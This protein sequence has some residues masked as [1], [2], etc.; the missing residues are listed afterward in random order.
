[1]LQPVRLLP[2]KIDDAA[3]LHLVKHFEKAA[4]TLSAFLIS[5]ALTIRILAVFEEA[6]ALMFAHEF[7]E[8]RS[9]RLP[10]HR[11]SFE[12]FEDVFNAGMP[13][14]SQLHLRCICRSR[15]RICPGTEIGFALD[16]EKNPAQVVKL[17][18]GENVRLTQP[19]PSR[20]S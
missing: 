11:E 6:R 5:S 4:F 3:S 9:V 2:W 8:C 12:I 16:V 7:D 19:Q 20:C 15:C 18:D 17:E 1:M 10:I 13:E 14:R